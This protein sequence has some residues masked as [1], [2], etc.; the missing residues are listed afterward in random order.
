MTIPT[1]PMPHTLDFPCPHCSAPVGQQCQMQ[2]GRPAPHAQR[3]ALQIR[4]AIKW[5]VRNNTEERK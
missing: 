4:A 1:D 3:S 2:N 5:A